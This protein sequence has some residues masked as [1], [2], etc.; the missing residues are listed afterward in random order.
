[1][2]RQTRLI[3][4]KIIKLENFLVEGVVGFVGVS[5]FDNYSTSDALK[6]LFDLVFNGYFI[7]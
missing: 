5:T 6:A 7:R 1:M 3:I 2:K 4:I